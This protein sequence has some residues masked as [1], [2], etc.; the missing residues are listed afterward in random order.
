VGLPS[1]FSKTRPAPNSSHG[2][3]GRAARV[4]HSDEL[5]PESQA[6]YRPSH[7]PITAARVPDQLPPARRRRAPGPTLW[8]E[9]AGV[10]GYNPGLAD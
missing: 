8:S 5:P 9:S 10:A 3:K 2:S 1:Q 6:N 4:I 7:R